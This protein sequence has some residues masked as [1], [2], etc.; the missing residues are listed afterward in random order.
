MRE[1][2]A[3]RSAGVSCP[4]C[5]WSAANSDAMKS[6]R[7]RKGDLATVT[8]AEAITGN[9]LMGKTELGKARRQNMRIL[10]MSFRC[11]CLL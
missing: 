1:T 4:C 6:E 8:V 2:R 7:P 9:W 3:Y 5:E 11:S 10:Q